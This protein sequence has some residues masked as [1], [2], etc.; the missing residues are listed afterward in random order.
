LAS[1][2]SWTKQAAQYG[3]LNEVE[4][5][6]NWYLILSQCSFSDGLIYDTVLVVH[7]VLSSNVLHYCEIHVRNKKKYCYTAL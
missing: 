2:A 3:N 6:H 1:N 7:N 4:V 5:I